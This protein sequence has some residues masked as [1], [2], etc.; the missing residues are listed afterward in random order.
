M[1]YIPLYV[2][3][4]D[5]I[6]RPIFFKYDSSLHVH[7]P[8]VW[9]RTLASRVRFQFCFPFVT[10]RR[11]HLAGSR[12]TEFLEIW[13]TEGN[14][15][16]LIMDGLVKQCLLSDPSLNYS[17]G[18]GRWRQ[19][20]TQMGAGLLTLTCVGR[21]LKEHVSK[22]RSGWTALIWKEKQ[23]RVYITSQAK[24]ANQTVTNRWLFHTRGSF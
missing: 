23:K 6:T 1:S 24:T 12:R 22:S 13:K 8:T 19:Q 2:V 10:T 16:W 7:P 9:Y 20:L 21:D 18:R 4:H 14:C 11:Q 3:H 15:E 5:I 17:K